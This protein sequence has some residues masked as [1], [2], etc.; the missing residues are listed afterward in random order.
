[1]FIVTG[2]AGFIGSN[3]VKALGKLEKEIVVV[4]DLTDGRK[5]ENL[6]GSEI[7]DYVDKDT[8]LAAILDRMESVPKKPISAIVHNGAIS[9]TTS[10]DGKKVMAENYDYSKILLEYCHRNKI[11]FIYAS[12]ASVYG[13]NKSS[14]EIPTNERPLNVYA[15]SKML[16]DKYVREGKWNNRVVGLRYFNVYGPGEQFKGSQASPFFRYHKELRYG[17][18]VR[19]FEGGDGFGGDAKN[20]KRDF[21]YVDDIVRVVLW[22]LENEHPPNTEGIFN[23]G[24][25]ECHSF[26]EVADLVIAHKLGDDWQNENLENVFATKEFE[27]IPYDLKGRSQPYTCANLTKLREAGYKEDFISIED[28]CKRYMQWLDENFSCRWD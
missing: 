28:G 24:T 23:V 16:F 12:S 1:M 11:P 3:I 5:F 18:S 26:E 27:L 9:S 13:A 22:A 4:D 14:V 20:T 7:A 2:G 19:V 10:W 15:Y 25:G 6:L 17:N 8:F 21:V